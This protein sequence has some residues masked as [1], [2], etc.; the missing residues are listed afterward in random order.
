[1]LITAL[2]L[3]QAF[4]VSYYFGYWG[5]TRFQYVLISKTEYVKIHITSLS[6]NRLGIIGI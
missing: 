3:L 4:F 2:I 1:M 5:F 6:T